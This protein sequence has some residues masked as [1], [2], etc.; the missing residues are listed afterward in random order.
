MPASVRRLAEGDLGALHRLGDSLRH[1]HRVAVAPYQDAIRA[2]VAADLPHR[3]QAALASGAEGLLASYRSELIR[4]DGTLECAYPIEW[5]LALNGRPLHL[6][7]SFF[8]TRW[9]VTPADPELPPVLVLPPAPAP[10]R[11]DRTRPPSGTLYSLGRLPGH[12]RAQVL[13]LLDRPMSTGGI[14]AELSSP[15]RA[16]AGT[17]RCSARR[18]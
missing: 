17:R 11:L 12:T 5:E 9:P 4:R 10:G 15:R 6:I 2:E 16:R 18:A 8:R 7:P 13:D 1:F 3:S 14:A